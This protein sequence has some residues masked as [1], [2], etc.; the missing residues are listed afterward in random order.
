MFVVG[1]RLN[2]HLMPAGGMGMMRPGAGGNAPGM[3][4]GGGYESSVLTS[5]CETNSMLDTTDDD[6]TTRS[7]H[8]LFTVF[9]V[10]SKS[11]FKNCAAA[12]CP[13]LSF[14]EI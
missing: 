12:Y 13:S 8:L 9:I 11:L 10:L 6:A 14:P 4:R 3:N 2:G 7:S 1:Q 5:E